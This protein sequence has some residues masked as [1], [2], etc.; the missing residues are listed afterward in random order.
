MYVPLTSIAT[1]EIKILS[2]SYVSTECRFYSSIYE[3]VCSHFLFTPAIV[4]HARLY[5]MLPAK[6][7]L[8]FHDRFTFVWMSD[9]GRMFLKIPVMECKNATD[10]VLSCFSQTWQFLWLHR[11]HFNLLLL[12]AILFRFFFS[13]SMSYRYLVICSTWKLVLATIT[14]LSIRACNIRTWYF[15]ISL[16]ITAELAICHHPLIRTC[17]FLL[18]VVFNIRVV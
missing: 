16:V 6:L 11:Q 12:F 15:S 3:R 7:S 17:K 14:R 8:S 10:H 4:I 1:K 18:L 13:F 2:R 9:G 5:L